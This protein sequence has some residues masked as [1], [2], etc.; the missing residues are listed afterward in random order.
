MYNFA[1]RDTPVR[2][3]EGLFNVGQVV[4]V[5]I[6]EVK[7]DERVLVASILKADAA[8]FVTPED[9]AKLEIGHTVSGNITHIHKENIVL[10]L[11]PTHIDALLSLNNI[12]NHRG[13]SVAQIRSSLKIGDTIDELMVVSKN[14]ANNLAI[15]AIKPKQKPKMPLNNSSLTIENLHTG[16]ILTGLVVKHSRKGSVVRL[17]KHVFGNLH[18]TDAADNYSSGTV[19]PAVDSVVRVA[20]LE[21]DQPTRQVVLSTR[22]SRLGLDSDIVDPEICGLQDL[23]IGQSVKG[24]VKSIVDHGVFVSLSRTLDARVQIRELFDEV[25]LVLKTKTYY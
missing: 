8:E 9:F 5:R 11:Q 1:D 12:A 6:A 7:H 16:Q 22:P 20:I 2:T 21:V 19:L 3:L 25:K 17:G 18:P 14:P 4:K 13:T 10:K 23:Q 15:V 24:L